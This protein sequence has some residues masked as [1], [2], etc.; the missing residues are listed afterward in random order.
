M[1]LNPALAKNV[2]LAELDVTLRPDPSLVGQPM[3]S[4]G[5]HTRP[6]KPIAGQQAR[7]PF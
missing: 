5:V 3:S 4:V 1:L 6:P 7:K 2:M